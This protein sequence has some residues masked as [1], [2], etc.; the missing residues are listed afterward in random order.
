[1]ATEDSSLTVVACGGTA[2]GVAGRNRNPW[3]EYGKYGAVGLELLL[4]IGV[5]YYL[6]HFL[7]ERFFGGK[8]WATGIGFLLGVYAGFKGIWRAAKKMQRDVEIAEKLERGDDPWEDDD[9]APPPPP[10]DAGATEAE[11]KGKAP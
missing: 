4:S 7:D 9:E 1:M 6:G 10:K 2:S 3:R 5:G 11:G 8:G